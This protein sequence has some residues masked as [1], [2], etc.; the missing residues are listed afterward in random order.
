[1]TTFFTKRQ[2]QLAGLPPEPEESTPPRQ[3]APCCEK[4]EAYIC[5]CDAV[6]LKCP[7]HHGRGGQ[8]CIPG[9]THD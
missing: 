4:A 7:V 3:W 9:N 8:P 6:R 5:G 1:M 2:R